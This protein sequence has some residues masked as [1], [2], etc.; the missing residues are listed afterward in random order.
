MVCP[1]DATGTSLAR[2]PFWQERQARLHSP[3]RAHSLLA[4][5]RNQ[6][7]WA[8][9]STCPTTQMRRMMCEETMRAWPMLPPLVWSGGFPGFQVL[10]PPI[11]DRG[12]Q[13]GF[14][15]GRLAARPKEGMVGG[16]LCRCAPSLRKP[17]K[18]AVTVQMID[19]DALFQRD[20]VAFEA[21][22]RR[23]QLD[24]KVGAWKFSFR[25]LSC[26]IQSHC[27][28][29]QST[30]CSSR[31]RACGRQRVAAQCASSAAAGWQATR[32]RGQWLSPLS[33]SFQRRAA[34][35]RPGLARSPPNEPIR[36]RARV[37]WGRWRPKNSHSCDPL[38]CHP[39]LSS[40]SNASM[41][42]PSTRLQTLRCR[43]INDFMM[44]LTA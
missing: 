35:K 32:V 13:M 20:E 22:D 17:L 12:R 14:D 24:A 4:G 31:N 36:G 27:L 18:C 40:R 10:V 33:Q 3:P 11:R 19:R 1:R 7:A 41:M 39:R 37:P 38:L 28:L 26:P 25:G 42:H 15:A 6:R 21:R 34:D 29:W 5:S 9:F 8:A 23:W 43:A 16:R 2:W 30:R 44:R